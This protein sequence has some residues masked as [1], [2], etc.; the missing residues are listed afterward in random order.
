[1]AWIFEV[2]DVSGRGIHLS[3][4]RWSHINLE[5]P[6][7]S[8]YLEELKETLTNPTKIT[9]YNINENIKYFYK[10]IKERKSPAKYLLIIVKY[11]NA[12]GFIITVYFVKHIK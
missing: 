3:K 1:M 5:H 4:E 10:Y 12:H 9:S 7:L 11:L 6:E 8:P 2:Q